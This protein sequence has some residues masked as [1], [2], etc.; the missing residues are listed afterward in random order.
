MVVVVRLHERLHAGLEG[1]ER[2]GVLLIL[3][4]LLCLEARGGL[5]HAQA[6]LGGLEGRG[7]VAHGRL[8]LL[9]AHAGPLRPQARVQVRPVLVHL[10][11][12]RLQQLWHRRQPAHELRKAPRGLAHRRGDRCRRGSATATGTR[13]GDKGVEL[14]ARGGGHARHGAASAWHVRVHELGPGARVFD[15]APRKQARVGRDQQAAGA[16]AADR[17]RG[18]LHGGAHLGRVRHAPEHLHG[19]VGDPLHERVRRGALVAQQV[20]VLA[21]APH[22][23]VAD[24]VERG[25][26]AL[27]VPRLAE[28]A[29]EV[30]APGAVARVRGHQVR[31]QDAQPPAARL[32]QRR[33]PLHRGAHVGLWRRVAHLQVRERRARR[34][35]AI[36]ERRRRRH[37]A[38]GRPRVR[39][40]AQGVLANLGRHRRARVRLRLQR[41]Q[42][43]QSHAERVVQRRGANR[44]ERARLGE[45]H[46]R[47]KRRAL[48]AVSAARGVDGVEHV[49]THGVVDRPARAHGVHIRPGRLDVIDALGVQAPQRVAALVVQLHLAVVRRVCARTVRAARHEEGA[50]VRGGSG[51]RLGPVGWHHERFAKRGRR[52]VCGPLERRN[53]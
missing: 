34:G 40:R 31:A 7:A 12:H 45:R 39:M 14:A 6:R 15:V 18:A 4:R 22:G 42:P 1:R 17:V 25:G 8:G 3:A 11:R 13:D 37:G 38:E 36:P 33:A 28:Q 2:V 21:R 47:R 35:G 23:L 52:P 20:K 9:R 46:A 16:A 44:G 51:A 5:G 19:A 30:V 41:R 32:G 29:R 50:R 53:R 49:P 48:R 10:G 24:F 26:D 27:R 43:A